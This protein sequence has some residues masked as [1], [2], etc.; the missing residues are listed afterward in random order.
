MGEW[1]KEYSLES[2]DLC[3]NRFITLLGIVE[4]IGSSDATW[5]THLHPSLS[6]RVRDVEIRMYGPD[7]SPM[8]LGIRYVDFEIGSDHGLELIETHVSC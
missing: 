8:S 5:D 2:Y 4:L 1:S 7:Y 3:C 6:L